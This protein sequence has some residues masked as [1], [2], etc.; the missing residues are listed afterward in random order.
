[1]EVEAQALLDGA[2]ETWKQYPC[3]IGKT[4]QGKN[5]WLRK[6]GPTNGLWVLH[7]CH[8]SLCKE[9][10]HMYLG[11]SADNERDARENSEVNGAPYKAQTYWQ[12]HHAEIARAREQ[13][14]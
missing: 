9:I 5:I 6:R 8:R 13:E 10:R 4:K 12:W 2:D 3:I 14:D 11:T 1:M 7:R